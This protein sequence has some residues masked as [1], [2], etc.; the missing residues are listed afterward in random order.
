MNSW[1]D[2]LLC[3][4]RP[5]FGQATT[6]I[7]LGFCLLMAAIPVQHMQGPRIGPATV[8][9]L[10]PDHLL[11]APLLHQLARV[12]LVGSAILWAMQWFIPW[13]CW[14]TV[15]A[16]TTVWAL[17][18]ENTYHADHI[19][20]VTNMLLVIH[21]MWYQF[22][23][24]EIRQSLAARQFWQTPLY[25]RWVFLLSVFY[26]GLYHTLAGVSKLSFSD[27]VWAN[28][29][30]LQ[31]WVHLW[32]WPGSPFGNVILENRTLAT[33]FQNAV[34]ILELMAILA[35]PLRRL[36]TVIGIGLLCFY[37][38]VLGT[39]VEFGF[40]FNAILVAMLLLPVEPYLRRRFPVG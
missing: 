26:I 15:I 4:S 30:S 6:L 31:L 27:L 2:N 13:S 21:A 37:A 7:L 9:S 12:F 33:I 11:S 17:R 1:R 8:L 23:C 3:L 16:F 29:L 5:H 20:N 32:G 14:A 34:L 25:P 35:L 10:L 19:F 40:Y 38:G 39:F 18:M 28:G 22:Y 36:R 24:P